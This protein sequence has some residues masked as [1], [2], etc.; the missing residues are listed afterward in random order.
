MPH[1]ESRRVSGRRRDSPHGTRQVQAALLIGGNSPK[2]AGRIAQFAPWARQ[3][4]ASIFPPAQAGPRRQPSRGQMRAWRRMDSRKSFGRV[5]LTAGGGLGYPRGIRAARCPRAKRT[6]RDGANG[7]KV[8]SGG[9][10]SGP[11]SSP[12]RALVSRI[13]PT[14]CGRLGA[15][16]AQLRRP[17]RG[18]TLW[19]QNIDR[20]F[21]R[22]LGRNQGEPERERQKPRLGEHPNEEPPEQR[23]G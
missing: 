17:A 22:R 2:D 20:L 10:L 4:G 5:D 7:K 13:G 12:A 14:G 8:L 21:R 3:P 15:L 19:R 6:G 9:N 23:T 18:K 11:A 16:G 1:G